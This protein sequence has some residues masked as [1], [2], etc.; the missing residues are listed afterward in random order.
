MKLK[1]VYIQPE[2]WV[3]FRSNSMFTI[4]GDGKLTVPK[5]ET[6]YG[7]F[8]TAVLKQNKINPLK[9]GIPEEFKSIIGDSDIAGDLNIWGPFFF[10]NENGSKK[11]FFPVPS[12]I[13]QIEENDDSKKLKNMEPNKEMK[14]D[15]NTHELNLPWIGDYTDDISSPD[16]ELIELAEL[17]NFKDGKEFETFCK[18]EIYSIESKLGIALKSSEKHTEESMIY[19]LLNYRFKENTGFFLFTDEKTYNLLKGIEEI[20]LG[21]KQRSAFV[22]YGEI[23]TSVF[24]KNNSNKKAI[25]LLTPCVF[26][27]G[28]IPKDGKLGS[29][30]IIS[31]VLGRKLAV[32]GWNLVKQEPKPI[33]NVVSPGSVYFLDGDIENDLEIS[34]E[35]SDFGY[36]KYITFNWDYFK[37][38]NSNE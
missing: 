23:E 19:T 32:S 14:Y 11:H 9:D 3:S 30:K 28:F 34:S 7:A 2:E 35:K 17:E 15:Y 29:S 16:G 12:S 36:G 5:I 31:A 18:S 26:D 8:K 37:G 13:Y 6:F 4:G 21:S 1:I 25:C 33:L 10:K 20:F 22:S 27:D 38:G 24:D